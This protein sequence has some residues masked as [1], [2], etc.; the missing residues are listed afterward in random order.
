VDRLPESVA[1]V[2]T[3]AIALELGQALHRLG[4]RITFFNP[5]EQV[6]TVS[7][8][9]I[10][11]SVREVLRA[12]LD[13]QVGVQDLEYARTPEGVEVK[14]SVSGAAQTSEYQWVLVV[15]G[16]RPNVSGLGLET[17]GVPLDRR[18]MPESFDPTTMQIADLPVFF[19]GDVNGQRPLLHEA[20]DEGGIAGRNAAGYPDD[21]LAHVRRIP[22]AIA[23]TEPNLAVAGRS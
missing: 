19:A 7:D 11:E 2:G 21:I 17:L 23:F 15:A 1:V 4:V 8:P 20:A 16:R 22:R 3:G 13:L 18:G 14:W 12:E 9:Q 5:F 6:G 10:D